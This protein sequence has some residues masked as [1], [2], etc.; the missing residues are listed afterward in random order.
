MVIMSLSSQ[1][2]SASVLRERVLFSNRNPA[3]ANLADP[4]LSINSRVSRGGTVQMAQSVVTS[5]TS[6]DRAARGDRHVG[7]QFAS[8]FSIKVSIAFAFKISST[9][10]FKISSTVSFEISSTF[11]FQI[12]SSFSFVFSRDGCSTDR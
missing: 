10:S 1:E 11:S 9:F 7:S 12:E 5:E 8:S 3:A 2:S 4:A 6:R